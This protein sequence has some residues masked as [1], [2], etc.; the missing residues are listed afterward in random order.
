VNVHHGGIY[1][2]GSQLELQRWAE[3]ASVRHG[4]RLAIILFLAFISTALF[5]VLVYGSNHKTVY[6]VVDGEGKR[7][8]TTIRTVGELVNQQKLK[9]E[10]K[11]FVSKPLEQEIQHGDTIEVEHAVGFDVRVDGK[12]VR[13]FTTKDDVFGA[14]TD[15]GIAL[16]MFDQIQP[17]L[18]EGVSEGM[19]ITVNRVIKEWVETEEKLKYNV[20]RKAD[21]SMMKGTEKVIQ[22][23]ESGKRVTTIKKVYIN[24]ELVE[25]QVV[26]E[27]DIKQSQNQVVVYGTKKPTRLTARSPV[28]QQIT[29]DQIT[30]D[31]RKILRNAELTAYSAGVEHTGKSEGH[32][33]YGITFTGT[34]VQ[35]GQTV[36]VDPRV[37]PLGWW[38]YIEGYGF[39]RTEDTGSAV[40]G[41][42]IDIY[43]DDNGIAAAFG[44]KK[45]ITVYIIGP[46]KPF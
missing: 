28:I 38:I 17:A 11:D 37:I 1:G 25:S 35:D 13:L 3:S 6:L 4:K 41:S 14:L 22:T 34:R 9:I 21:A 10:P 26:S 24:G 19:T 5:V 36:A 18:S 12:T 20:V 30:F 2:R 46:N 8:D 33:E 45:G 23:G 44:L 7:I 29:R 40:K 16:G 15:N 31:V 39:R 27:K 42:R 43:Y 32:P